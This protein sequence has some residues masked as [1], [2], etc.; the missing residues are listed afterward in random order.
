MDLSKLTDVKELK[1]MAYDQIMLKEQAS[2]NLQM[3]GQRLQQLEPA[4][5]T[6]AEAKPKELGLE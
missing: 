6:I 1:V 3:I 5:N 4:E 2:A